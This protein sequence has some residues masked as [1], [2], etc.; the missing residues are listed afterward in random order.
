[1]HCMQRTLEKEV[2]G[3]QHLILWT[4]GDREGE[5]IADEIVEVVTNGTHVHV[6][7]CH[8][9]PC[10]SHHMCMHVSSHVHVSSHAC[11]PPPPSEIPWSFHTSSEIFRDHPTVSQCIVSIVCT[12]VRV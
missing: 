9:M 4:D 5:N 6:H 3:C 7:A 2:R 11:P 1:M 8:H 12:C 10:M